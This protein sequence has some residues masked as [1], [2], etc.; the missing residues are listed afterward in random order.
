MLELD[1]HA[2]SEE[3]YN[4]KTLAER[5]TG[6]FY[7]PTRLANDLA[8]QM[9]SALEITS[10]TK[11]AATDPFCG[12]GRLILALLSVSARNPKLSKLPWLIELRDREAA[13]ANTAAARVCAM[14]R[15]LGMNVK[16][17]VIV[18]DTF[19]TDLSPRFDFV[20][21]NPPWELLKP[22]SREVRHL[23]LLGAKRY[24]EDLRALSR[25]LDTRF[26]AARAEGA[27]GGWGTNLARCGWD[28][29]LSIARRGGVIGIILPATIMGDQSSTAIRRKAFGSNR[30]VDAATYPSEA[31]LFERVDQPVVALTMHAGSRAAGKGRIRSF[32]AH[33]SL[34]SEQAVILN[35]SAMEARNWTLPFGPPSGAD[36]LAGKFS[37]LSTLQS[38]EGDR[39][40]NLWLGRELDE[41][42]L[43]EK[44]TKGTRYPFVKGRMI[45]RHG[46]IEDPTMS[47]RPALCTGF[48]STSFPRAVWRDVARATSKRRMIGTVIPP[49]WVAGNSLH[50]AC[51]RD[52]KLDRT[53]ALHA[54]LSS[55]VVEAQVRARLTTG[56][57]SL[58]V[59]RQARM[60]ELNDQ[61][62]GK[63]SSIAR[64]A[65]NGGGSA[66]EHRLEITVAKAYGLNRADMARLLD[67]FP[68]LE[69]WERD[70]LTSVANWN[71]CRL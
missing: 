27:W 45:S 62:V 30:I 66:A 60:P 3:S 68:K 31:R 54:L 26:P 40:H 46:V 42:R 37:G 23:S 4:G 51:Y 70:A 48:H 69:D 47:V 21:T 59:V 15:R 17:D 18:G 63:L 44:V 24:K 6:R 32:D 57:M 34:V 25:V 67:D 58:G 61:L 20:I 43:A 39:P 12:D 38:W 49:G 53:T 1:S 55:F 9:I 71:E 2:A 10:L 50:V 7:T 19:A 36:E 11:I 65:M 16:T 52:G 5:A 8:E 14:A 13:A 29:S 28:L 64:C 56:H 41:T 33:G 35:R 22:D